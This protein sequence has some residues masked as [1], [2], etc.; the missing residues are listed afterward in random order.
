M[1]PLGT[2]LEPG[3]YMVFDESNFNP[4]MGVDPELHPLD[5]ALNGAEGDDVYLVIPDGK[6]GIAWFADDVHFGATANFEPIGRLAKD[7]PRLAPMRDL[8]LGSA[9]GPPRV[10]PLIISEVHY[11]PGVPSSVALEADPDVASEDLEFVEVHN[12]TNA[13]IPLMDWRIRGGVDFD[14]DES[15]TIEAGETLV[16]ISFNPDNVLNADRLAA[17]RAHYGL[18][19]DFPLLGGYRDQLSDS[20]ERLQ[21][22]RPGAPPPEQPGLIPRLSEDEV[23][24]DDSTPW[25]AADGD[26]SSLSRRRPDLYGNYATSWLAK[27]PSPG[28]VEFVDGVPGDLTG[29][30]IVNTDD[31]DALLAAI[32]TG[33]AA[34]EFD[35][36]GNQS[37]DS[38][39]VVFLLENIL[40]SFVGDTNLDGKVNSQ[41]LNRI[42]VNWR[43]IE[44]VRWAD[45][46]LTGDGRITAADLNLLA[47]NWQSGVVVAAPTPHQRVPR[48]PLAGQIIPHSHIGTQAAFDERM[49]GIESKE[50]IRVDRLG[51]TIKPIQ[52]TREAHRLAA[53][54]HRHRV[55]GA[56]YG[57]RIPESDEVFADWP[58]G[59][60]MAELSLRS[61]EK[62]F[63]GNVSPRRR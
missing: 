11:N 12:P 24:Y 43:A 22:Q 9:N 29:D 14:F 48:A 23:L 21:L 49:A 19:D 27:T 25:A 52:I 41:D 32:N 57:E 45:G 33:N 34:A 18:A 26:G 28:S 36:D 60:K 40:G 39:D 44:N 6:G 55:A 16:I 17:F 1:I 10:G 63:L 5:F 50:K 59:E 8:T 47:L 61:T 20:G 13:A 56:D 51:D 3:E 53:S 30:G 31:I 42:G 54:N 7:N 46:D 35:L 4:S 15:T 62:P 37:V 38:D 58:K 2:V